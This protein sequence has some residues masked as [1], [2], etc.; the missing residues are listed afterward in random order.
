MPSAD[1]LPSSS[2]NNTSIHVVD[3]VEQV[4][5]ITEEDEDLSELMGECVAHNY[6]AKRCKVVR[7]LFETRTDAKVKLV[8]L[9]SGSVAADVLNY[10]KSELQTKGSNDLIIIWYAGKASGEGMHYYW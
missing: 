9:P 3:Y 6:H 10:F 8:Q 1:I 7:S 5:E 4:I 2:F